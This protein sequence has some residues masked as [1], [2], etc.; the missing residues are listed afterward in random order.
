MT[1]T[2]HDSSGPPRVL[3]FKFKKALTTL[4]RTRTARAGDLSEVHCHG[5]EEEF[6]SASQCQES[7][8]RV[9]MPVTRTVTPGPGSATM[10]WAWE[11]AGPGLTGTGRLP[12][13][14]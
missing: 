6:I 9:M 3:R 8:I 14:L 11:P 7:V 13:L 4:S 10:A 5:A 12:V 2:I 1:R